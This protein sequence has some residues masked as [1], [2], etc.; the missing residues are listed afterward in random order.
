M[1]TVG[2]IALWAVIIASIGIVAGLLFALARADRKRIEAFAADRGWK[3]KSVSW[4]PVYLLP[5]YAQPSACRSLVPHTRSY[6]RAVFVTESG[7]EATLWFE[8]TFRSDPIQISNP[9]PN[10]GNA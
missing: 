2:F 3:L 6:F 8:S 9:F 1:N 7:T 5:P 10:D 4:K